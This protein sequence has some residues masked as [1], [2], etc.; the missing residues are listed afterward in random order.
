MT[1]PDPAPTDP[2][3]D[4]LTE[5]FEDPVSAP[6]SAEVRGRVVPGESAKVEPLYAT[7]RLLKSSLLD[8]DRMRE[9]AA[10][11]LEDAQRRAAE[12][13]EESKAQALARR[14]GI[15]AELRELRESATAEAR[16]EAT[17]Q[18]GRLLE[19][20]QSACQESYGRFPEWV[21]ESAFKVARHVVEAEFST[22]PELIREFVE[23]ALAKARRSAMVIHL[24]PEDAAIIEPLRAELIERHGLPETFQVVEAQDVARHS[25]RVETGANRAAYHLGVDELFAELKKQIERKVRR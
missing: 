23:R 18:F 7:S 2:F 13:T 1:N 14:E 17:K 12:L 22:R 9:E 5:T 16:A 20:F 3:S 6:S 8:V 11:T 4:D 15:D 10:R 25:V 24:H 21:R 19:G